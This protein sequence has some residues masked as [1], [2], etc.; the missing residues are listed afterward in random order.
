MET[1][2]AKACFGNSLA[3]VLSIHA[4]NFVAATND[5]IFF[6]LDSW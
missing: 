6:C 1:E 3:S 5:L 2:V 4:G